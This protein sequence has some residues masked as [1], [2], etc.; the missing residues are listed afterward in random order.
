MK[1]KIIKFIDLYIIWSFITLISIFKKNKEEKTY[2]LKNYKN[3]LIIRPGWIWDAV[4][5]SKLIEFLKNEWKNI[6]ILCMKRN[7][8]FFQILQWE[9]KINNIFLID[10]FKSLFYLIWKK[11]DVIFDTEQYF[12]S[13]TFIANFFMK[14]NLFIWFDTNNRRFLYDKFIA[15]KQEDYEA[16]SFLNLLK[17]FWIDRQEDFQKNEVKNSRILTIFNGAS[18]EIRKVNLESLI[19]LINSISKNYEKIYIIWWKAEEDEW[20]EIVKRINKISENLAGKLNL[21]WTL[22]ILKKSNTLISTDSWPLHLW[23]YAWVP[24]IYGIFWPWIVEK[25]WKWVD[26]I[27]NEKLSCIWC[28]YWRFWQTPKCPYKYK[29]IKEINFNNFNIK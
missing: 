7:K 10:D 24:K 25:W 14:K 12:Y 3:F 13:W 19:I 2:E 16:N 6:D 9:N 23:V 20:N 17:A 18:N 5:S 28:N 22:E 4:L 11:Y 21:K 8:W 1:E 15:Y 27:R 26:I 29:C